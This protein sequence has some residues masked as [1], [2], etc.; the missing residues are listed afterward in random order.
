MALS[1]KRTAVAVERLEASLVEPRLGRKRLVDQSGEIDGAQ[2]ARA[3]RGQRLLAAIVR[4]QAVGVEGVDPWN[5]HVED[6]LDAVIDDRRDAGREA[7]AIEGA[8]VAASETSSRRAL[9][10]SAKPTSQRN[11]RR[12]SPLTTSSCWGCV[13]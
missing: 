10:W 9:S 7:L 6:V 11:C 8:L 2:Q 4:N 13:G 5:L 1:R 3:V 12:F